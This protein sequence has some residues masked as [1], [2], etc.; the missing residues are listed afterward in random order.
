MSGKSIGV[1]LLSI[2]VLAVLAIAAAA[3][4]WVWKKGGLTGAA[5]AA[6]AAVVNAAQA[7]TV[8]AVGAVGAVIGLPSPSETTDDPAAVRWIID[9]YGH[10]PASQW[11]SAL[12]L[13]RAELMSSGSGRPPDPN[14]PA[15]RQFPVPVDW[16]APDQAS[17]SRY[18]MGGTGSS[19]GEPSTWAQA[20]GYPGFVGVFP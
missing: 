10:M 17:I 16:T 11:G 5:G 20:P 2:E 15:G 7:A 14:S 13:L 18:E 4:L 9:T 3:G 1:S 19:N 8:G 12:A 6:G